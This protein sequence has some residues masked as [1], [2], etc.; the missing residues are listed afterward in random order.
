[1]D[2]GTSTGCT[3]C[4]RGRFGAGGFGVSLRCTDC[5]HGKYTETSGASRSTSCTYD[6]EQARQE[7]QAL[8]GNIWGGAVP[9]EV[10]VL[11]IVGVLALVVAVVLRRRRRNKRSS[12]GKKPV[13]PADDTDS[14]S[15]ESGSDVGPSNAGTDC[16]TD[17]E[18]QPSA[19]MAVVMGVPG[20]GKGPGAQLARPFPPRAVY[21]GAQIL[22]PQITKQY[23]V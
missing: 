3:P 4:P 16:D 7:E 2:S 23:D 12:G 1:M 10:G 18:P 6:A 14:L 13:I 11:V 15:D 22:T 9:D 21:A 17:E 19:K 5:P 20:G 8:A